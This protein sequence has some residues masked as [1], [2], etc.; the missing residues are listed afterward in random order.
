[1]G[2]HQIKKNKYRIR[3]NRGIEREKEYRSGS[4]LA[5]LSF[6]EMKG[7]PELIDKSVSVINDK[8]QGIIMIKKIINRFNLTKK[9]INNAITNLMVEEGIRQRNINEP[10]E[11]KRD[12]KGNIISPFSNR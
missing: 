2:R 1:M 6:L 8:N 3:S 4:I 11:W 9:D 7:T 12:E 5:K 10:I